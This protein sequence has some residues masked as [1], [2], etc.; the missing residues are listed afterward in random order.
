M[1]LN[2][3]LI[4]TNI[5][6]LAM[7]GDTN[8]V[9]ILQRVES[10]FVTPVIVG[11]LLAGFKGG[12]R[13]KQNRIQLQQFLDSPRVAVL[14]I[15]ENTSGFYSAVFHQLKKSGKPI[16]TN[17]LWIAASALQHQLALFSRDRHFEYV[18]NIN[19]LS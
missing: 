19:L 16:P 17:D 12:N 6:S 10:I 5:Y 2:Q 9:S 3:I 14:N 18:N 11:E 1:E 15:D 13:E 4:D 7:R 8:I